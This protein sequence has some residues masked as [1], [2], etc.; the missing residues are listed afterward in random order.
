MVCRC[1]KE[2]NE[3][4]A[5]SNAQLAIGFG[6]RND[7]TVITRLIIG[8]EKKKNRAVRTKPPIVSATFCPF[9]GTKFDGCAMAEPPADP[10]DWPLP[11]DVSVGHVTIT[12]GCKLRTLVARVQTLHAAV[13]QV[14][15]QLQPRGFLLHW[16]AIGGGRQLVW[17]ESRL[18][19]DAIGCPVEPVYTLGVDAKRGDSC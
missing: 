15:R 11:C 16:P 1:V 8:T 2:V 19:G 17:D 7:N 13:A 10:L 18:A 3:Q 5:A 4:L 6:I 9:C 14:E 12:K